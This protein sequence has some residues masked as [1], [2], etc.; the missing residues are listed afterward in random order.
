MAQRFPVQWN[1]KSV[2]TAQELQQL[3][4]EDQLKDERLAIMTHDGGL[5]ENEALAII[6]KRQ[7]P[8]W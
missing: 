4:I 3:P 2:L 8:L 7:I 1:E 6:E 5:T